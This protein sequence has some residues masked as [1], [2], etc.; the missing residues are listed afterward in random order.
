MERD[1][2]LKQLNTKSKC[3]RCGAPNKCAIESGKSASACWC[4]GLPTID[5]PLTDVCLCRKCLTDLQESCA[6]L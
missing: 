5:T 2:L 3:S 1:K 4:M 6:E